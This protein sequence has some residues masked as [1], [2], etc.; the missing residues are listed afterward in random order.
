MT[1]IWCYVY[2]GLSILVELI[3]HSYIS[4]RLVAI[5]PRITPPLLNVHIHQDRYCE[6]N[7]EDEEEECIADIS[8][9]VGN[10]ANNQ[11]A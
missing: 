10:E 11:W 1:K 7:H 2:R 9:A 8:G 4:S 5:G 3:Y 6:P